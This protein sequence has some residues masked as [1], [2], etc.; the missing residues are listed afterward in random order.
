MKTYT[1]IGG[2]NGAGKSS[3]TGVLKTRMNLGRI[4][5]VD[6]IAHQN[7]LTA[8]EA[9]KKA[10]AL[11]EECL[12]KGISFAQETTLS[13]QKTLSTI[14]RAHELGYDVRLFYVGLD[15]AEECILRIQNRVAKGGHDI[16]KADVIRR[17]EDR[18][19]SLAAVLPCCDEAVFFDNNN[20]F[21]EVAEYKNGELTA[22]SHSPDW[23][24]ELLKL[25]ID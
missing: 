7:R 5:D 23:L 3:L 6:K 10:V 4:I 12:E 8:M 2:I 13:G 11:I 18:V 25:L 17:F 24:K 21:C 19:K 14:K 1:I 22:K 9:G 16:P 15:T 20:G